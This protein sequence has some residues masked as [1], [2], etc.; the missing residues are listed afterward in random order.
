VRNIGALVPPASAVM[1]NDEGAALEYA[2]EVLGVRQVV[3]CGHS[4][5]GAMKALK[6]GEVPEGL[7]ALGHWAHTAAEIVPDLHAFETVDDA[8]RA[9]TVRQVENVLSYP[10]IASR[11]AK[12]ELT[13][14]A[15]FYDIERAEVLAWRP[16]EGRYVD[17][18]A[19]EDPK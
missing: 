9:T 10:V 13:V 15:W 12:G 18:G 1:R 19:Q 14:Q 17:L 4:K 7:A 8:T 11:V 5:C 3:V 16:D 2:I 6:G